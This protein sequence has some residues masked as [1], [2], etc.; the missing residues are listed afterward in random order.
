MRRRLGL[1]SSVLS[2]LISASLLLWPAVVNRYPL[3]FGDT[4]V[5]I[6][7][8]NHLH[9]TWARPMFYGLFMLP[10]HLKVTT[11][12]VVIA[13]SLIAAIALLIT[14]RSFIPRV[15]ALALIP[16]TLV[17]T[18]G[19][20]L[21]WFV[22]QLMPDL[23]AGL[24]VLALAVL[25]LVPERLNW[26]GQALILLFASACI[27]MHLSLLPISLAIIVVL[28]LARFIL[29]LPFR[30]GDFIRG[31][32]VP[33]IAVA[34]IIAPN[35]VFLG[36]ISPSPYGKI[37]VLT[38]VLIDGP[39][40]RALERECPHPGWTLCDFKG[41]FGSDVDSVLWGDRS[42]LV[43]AGGHDVV[44]DQAMPIILS[45]VRAEP[46]AVLLDVLRNTVAQFFS[47]ASGDALLRPSFFNDQTWT[48]EFPAAEQARYRA[49]RQY[50]GLPLLPD[51]LQA[52]HLGLASVCLIV[53]VVGAGLGLQR[54]RRLGGLYAAILIALLANAF[55]TGALSGVFD[56]YQS[57]FVWLATFAVLLMLLDWR[58]P[59]PRRLA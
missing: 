10:L 59:A 23:F 6:K 2:V 42:I 41:E 18:V 56:R 47:F 17:L 34:V 53:L 36:K 28:W 1:A 12:P 11:W 29:D 38:R 40:E 43:R 30:V 21:P 26:L 54:G 44:A 9:V 27:T 5:Y 15:S 45:A 57:R 3:L 49:G 22:S 52:L 32:A 31:A 4:G 48:Q 16:V 24:L 13:Q 8:G 39:G 14:V 55:V 51:W 19:T 50:Q 20:S 33:A 25:L 58:R 7:D 46:G 35:A 37:F